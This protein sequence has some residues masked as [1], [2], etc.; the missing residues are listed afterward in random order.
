M[1]PLLDV[2]NVMS[3]FGNFPVLFLSSDAA[4]EERTERI[5]MQLPTMPCADIKHVKT[6]NLFLFSFASRDA[7]LMQCKTHASECMHG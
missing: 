2:L 1:G 3:I 4:K 7:W 5:G 6:E